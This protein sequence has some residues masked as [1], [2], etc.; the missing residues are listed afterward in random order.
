MEIKELQ[1]M[2]NQ[3][4]E[5]ET[6]Y[7]QVLNITTLD[8]TENEVSFQIGKSKLSFVTASADQPVYHIAFDIPNN[9]LM[10]A[11][12]WLKQRTAIL[13]VTP[14]T[15]FSNFELWNAKSFYFHDNNKNLL[16]FIC[17]SDLN[18]AAEQPF[19]E[20]L[21]LA[22]SEIGLVADDVPFLAETLMSKYDL[23]VYEKQPAQDNFTV[24]GDEHGLLILVNQDRDWYP[25]TQKA[26]PYPVKLIFNNGNGEDQE[27]NIS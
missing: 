13:P 19:D 25:T 26:K 23:E 5:T 18:N 6:F 2:T 9:K 20:S 21:M 4:E 17:R 22:I 1:I 14:D 7:N 3:L 16:E 11:F 24:L 27:L 12:E 8:K 15:N 10:E